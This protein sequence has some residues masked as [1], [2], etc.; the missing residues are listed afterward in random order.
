MLWENFRFILFLGKILWTNAIIGN[1]SSMSL[2]ISAFR[3][4]VHGKIGVQV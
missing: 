3:E 4:M 2:D 1:L